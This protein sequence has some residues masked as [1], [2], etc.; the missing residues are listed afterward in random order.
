MLLG[1]DPGKSKTGWAMVDEGGNLYASGII[2]NKSKAEIAEII[3][4]RNW[5][6]LETGRTE[7][8]PLEFSDIS[9]KKVIIGKGTTSEDLKREFEI[10]GIEFVETDE[11]NT[12]LG[13]RQEYWNINKPC[14]LRRLI[15][16][17]KQFPPRDTDDIAAL[18]ILRRYLNKSSN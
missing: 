13:S 7:G 14:M 3:H 12:T 17:L 8:Q 6:D 15:P 2:R 11:S 5:K 10:R 16:F 1:I 4:S 18:L 9:V